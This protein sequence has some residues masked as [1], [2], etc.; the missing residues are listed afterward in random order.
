[1]ALALAGALL[2]AALLFSHANPV[3][4]IAVMCAAGIFIAPLTSLPTQ[5]IWLRIPLVLLAVVVFVLSAFGMFSTDLITSN[6]YAERSG[7]IMVT[8]S[9][10]FVVGIF[11]LSKGWKL[12]EKGITA[13]P[14][15]EKRGSPLVRGN[16][17]QR[18]LLFRAKT[19]VICWS[20]LD[21]SFCW[22]R[23]LT[24]LGKVSSIENPIPN[25]VT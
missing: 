3:I 25:R 22:P 10:A 23:G 7:Q 6:K 2:G 19:T 8:A 5:R 18:R 21:S 24:L 13:Q 11:W 16:M 4:T 20:K 17:P 9:V 12:I 15:L 14:A 1:M